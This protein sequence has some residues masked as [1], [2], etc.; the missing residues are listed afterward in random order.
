M[1]KIADITKEAVAPII[2]KL[3]YILVD[4]EYKKLN[5]QN[6]IIIYIDKLGGITLDD[7]EL[8]SKKLDAILDD[9]N[10]TNDVPYNLNISSP[11]LDRPL[12]L[13]WDF[14]KN[15]N[16]EVEVKFYVPFN[17]K[18]VITGILKDFKYNK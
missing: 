12:K 9:L 17:G 16:K 18:K 15:L 11:G 5:N 1:G 13:D 10:P 7:C 14:T 8:V 4:V 6:T 3:N 2:E